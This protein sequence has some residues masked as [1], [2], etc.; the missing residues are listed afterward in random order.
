MGIFK[1]FMEAIDNI[2]AIKYFRKRSKI[3]SRR[4]PQSIK[5]AS[6]KVRQKKNKLEKNYE[7]I[8]GK[9]PPRRNK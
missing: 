7:R 1:K 8:Y 6:N 3:K 9:K 4:I 5:K 2:A